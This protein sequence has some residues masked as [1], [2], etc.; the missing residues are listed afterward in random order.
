MSLPCYT[1]LYIALTYLY[2]K[3]KPTC[4]VSNKIQ[5]CP[6]YVDCGL[7]EEEKVYQQMHTRTRSIFGVE[8]GKCKRLR[9]EKKLQTASIIT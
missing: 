3:A 5:K 1:L 4:N 6:V 9:T 8:Y 7:L 2:P